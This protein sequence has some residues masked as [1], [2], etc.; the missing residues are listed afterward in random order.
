MIRLLAQPLSYLVN[1]KVIPWPV[2]QQRCRSIRSADAVTSYLWIVVRRGVI[3]RSDL[4]VSLSQRN[5]HFGQNWIVGD[6]RTCMGREGIP[7]QKEEFGVSNFEND[8][9]IVSAKLRMVECP[10]LTFHMSAQLFSAVM[11]CSITLDASCFNYVSSVCTP[12]S[13]FIL[14][15]SSLLTPQ[16]Y[17]HDYGSRTNSGLCITDS[18]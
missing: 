10:I 3:F 7:Q 14:S 5:G 11:H 4:G 15:P 9:K 2:T 8:P 16:Q 13:L 6:D 12:S 17:I 1:F 18:Q